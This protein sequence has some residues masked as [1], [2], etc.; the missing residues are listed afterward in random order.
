MF[1]WKKWL[2]KKG[3]EVR[4]KRARDVDGNMICLPSLILYSDANHP[5]R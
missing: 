2:A 3:K 4:P 5:I 1:I